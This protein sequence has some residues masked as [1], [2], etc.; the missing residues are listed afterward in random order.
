MLTNLCQLPCDEGSLERSFRDPH[1]V[2]AGL[3]PM[4]HNGASPRTSPRDPAMDISSFP[5]GPS[6]LVA[7]RCH[8]IEAPRHPLAVGAR[9]MSCWRLDRAL[10]CAV[11]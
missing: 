11:L 9:P 8:H 5:L 1:V 4:D 2:V 7:T 3:I 10:V 6:A